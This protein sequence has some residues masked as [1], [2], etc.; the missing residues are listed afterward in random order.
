MSA[1][2][3]EGAPIFMWLASPLETPVARVIERLR[4]TDDVRHVAVM[5]DVHLA[6][7]VCVGVALA[8]ERLL[9]PAAVGGDIGCGMLAVAFDADAALLGDASRA[10]QLMRLLYAAVPSSRRHRSRAT[11]YPA[12]LAPERL[13]HGALQGLARD[14][15]LLQLGTLGGGNHFVEFQA[16]EAD[17]RLWLMIHTGSR[18]M[19]QGVRGH[20]CARATPANTRLL[21]LD[22]GQ[23]AGRAYMNDLE[24]TRRYADANRRAIASAV[25]EVMRDHFGVRADQTTLATCDHNHVALEEHGGKSLFVHR[26]GAMPATEGMAGLLPGSMGTLSYHVMGRGHAAA[27]KSSAHG[28]G[29]NLSRDAARRRYTVR[30]LA[31]QM[32]GVWFDP[33]LAAQLREEAPKAYKDVRKVLRAEHELVTVT[34]TLRPVLTY[35]GV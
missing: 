12:E 29:R 20:H 21:A 22:A 34:R 32:Q 28:A 23:E 6:A 8:T 10:G 15:G 4:Q 19:G 11:P 3:S 13:S 30:D 35:K 5:P 2:I 14:E 1:E 25:C 33:R 24:W 26:K 16:D 7:D 9:Y 31:S 17:G 18:A 27:L